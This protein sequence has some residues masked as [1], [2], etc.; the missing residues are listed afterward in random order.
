M[1]RPFRF[2]LY[3]VVLYHAVAIAMMYILHEN[4]TEIVLQ[5]YQ[6]NAHLLLY[7]NGDII[8]TAIIALVTLTMAF[9]LERRAHQF[10]VIYAFFGSMLFY[11]TF[12]MMKTSLPL[13]AP[14][15]ADPFWAE[16][17]RLL[18]FGIDPW[19]IV[20]VHLPNLGFP[21]I[22]ARIASHLYLSIWFFIMLF[23][24]SIVAISDSDVWRKKRFVI[25]FFVCWLGLGNVLA[26]MGL[27]VGPVFYDRV[28]DS[29]RFA[30]FT[31]VF[32]AS[33][34][35]NSQLKIV[36][37]FLWRGFESGSQELGV[38]I[39]AFPSV[40]VGMTTVC[41]LYFWE[42]FWALGVIMGLFWVFIFIYSIASG[43]HYALDGYAS[44]LVVWSVWR[45]MLRQE[46]LSA[47]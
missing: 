44:A 3:F 26:L 46:R 42:R 32:N 6:Q 11:P 5:Y 41:V 2:F 12:S 16:F 33:E 17:D 10:A 20:L 38:G 18:H 25:M 15:F 30:E 19:E 7:L 37:G 47:S 13:L 45:F 28:Y 23:M 21:S 24:P 40:H 9:V 43:Y 22:P 14:Y 29:T 34:I 36:Q 1:H 35:G 31:A 4:G 39:S 8:Q 27:S